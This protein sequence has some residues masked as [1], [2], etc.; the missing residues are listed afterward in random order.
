MKS[1]INLFLIT[2]VALFCGVMTSCSDDEITE[3][4]AVLASTSH[5]SFPAKNVDP[6]IITITSDGDWKVEAPDW[7]TVTPATG[8]AGQTDVT[9]VCAENM[10]DGA[11]DLPRK[12]DVVFKGWTIRGQAKVTVSQAGDKFRDLSPMSIEAVDALDE[13]AAVMFKDLTVY[14]KTAKGFIGTDGTKFVYCLGDNNLNTGDKVDMKGSKVLTDNKMYT[15]SIDEV[16][17]SVSG[18][19]VP[20]IAA[21]DV[22]ADLDKMKVSGRALI[23]TTGAYNGAVLKVTGKTNSVQFDDN[24]SDIDLKS[25]VGHQLEVTGIYCGTASPVVRMV[26]TEVKDLGLNEFI[27]LQDDFTW[28]ASYQTGWSKDGKFIADCT[29]THSWDSN[30]SNGYNPELNTVKNDDGKSVR[31]DFYERGY[32]YTCLPDASKYAKSLCQGIN[33]L[34]FG[35]SSQHP[36]VT[37]PP[38]KAENMGEG[39]TGAKMKIEYNPGTENPEI[40]IKIINNGK[41]SSYNIFY[42]DTGGKWVEDKQWITAEIDIAET[43]TADTKVT[44]GLTD[45]QANLT[46]NVRWLLNSYKIYKSKD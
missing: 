42:G 46:S 30:S 15:V 11:E 44:I 39:V 45:A 18:G 20:A 29:A 26:V 24:A 27:Y 3:A 17:N 7:M 35:A 37:L 10:R 43:L 38:F 22:T 21:T 9:I 28:M 34:K 40:E 32:K 41:E 33:Q 14:S 23:K 6:T 5:V 19:T 16:S 4:S 1:K 2:M 31:D 8:G 12:Y 25:L 36:I 13:D